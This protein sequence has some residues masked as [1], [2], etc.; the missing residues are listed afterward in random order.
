MID[1]RVIPLRQVSIP[2]PN[3]QNTASGVASVDYAISQK[4]SLRGRFLSQ[5]QGAIDPSAQLYTFSGNIENNSYITTLSEFHNFSPT[6]VNELRLGY[7]RFNQSYP[8][9]RQKFPGLD[10]F[11]NITIDELGLN[12]GPD[13]SAPQYTVQNTYQATDNLSWVKAAHQLSFGVNVEKFI[14]PSFFT[15][16]V[17]GDYEWTSLASYVTDSDPAF[18]ERSLGG[19]TY[20]GDQIQFGIYVNDDWKVLPNLTLNLGVRYDRT[21]IPYSERL[22]A[23][24]DLA[25]VPGVLV[26]HSPEV[27]NFNFQPRVGF[28]YSPGTR[29]NTSIRGGFGINYDQ[30]FDNLGTLSLPRNSRRQ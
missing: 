23:M 1:G 17:R 21:T 2:A 24:N 16:R 15:Q 18:A 11:P 22:Q 30:L 7:T 28:A 3:Y 27:Q 5:R 4:D 8:I 25:S 12:L 10:A 13:P 9:G 6:L 26:F 29:G 19:R 14:S 20:Y